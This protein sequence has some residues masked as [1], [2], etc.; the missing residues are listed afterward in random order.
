MY[1]DSCGQTLNRLVQGI[2]VVTLLVKLRNPLRGQDRLA[3]S[4]G[5]AAANG[6]ATMDLALTGNGP[7]AI[8]W[9][10]TYPRVA[11]RAMAAGL[12]TAAI[13]NST[14][15]SPAGNAIALFATGG[16]LMGGAILPAV[17]SVP[18]LPAI[19]SSSAAV[20]PAPSP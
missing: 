5:T 18:C 1:R 3:L 15:S 7:A 11:N 16:N 20:Q 6:S 10:L 13:G 2:F 8:N 12:T 17:A 4:F 14:E 19:L 9:M